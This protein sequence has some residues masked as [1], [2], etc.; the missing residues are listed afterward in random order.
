MMPSKFGVIRPYTSEISLFARLLD[1]IVI[2]LT[3]WSIL[4]MQGNIWDAKQ[5]WWLLVSIVTFFIFAEWN[6]IYKEKRGD[7]VFEVIKSILMAWMFVPVVMFFVEYS[8][9][10]VDPVYKE[11]YIIWIVTVP[12]EIASWHIFINS[13]YRIIRKK[14]R[15]SRRVAIIGAT[16]LGK[17]LERIF[18]EEEELGLKFIGYF[19]DRKKLREQETGEYKVVGNI[20][21]LIQ[22]AKN[23]EVDIIYIALALQAEQRIKEMLEELAD[24][25]IS[26]YFVP[27][28]FVFSLLRSSWSNLQGIPVVSIYDS[29]FYGVD[30]ALKRGFDICFSFITLICIFW[31]LLLI[32]VCIKLSSP[33]PV[34]FKQRRFGLKGEEI[35]VWKFRSMTV[36]E[37]G[38]KVDQAKKNDPRVT[39]L[40]AFLRR[41]SLDELPQFFNVLQGRMSV[42]GPRPHAVA[43]NEFYRGQIKGYMLRHKVKPGITGLA[44]ISGYRGETDT[45]DKMENRIR[46]DLEYIR[47]WSLAL[48]IK[49]IFLTLFKGFVGKKA[50]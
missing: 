10:L 28:L 4:E 31:L 34:I 13:L 27:N 50:Y 14:G 45:L 37:D 49:I 6:D 21:H 44:Q 23:S 9:P 2:G 48:D 7:F 42:V 24:T 18:L 35:V 43:H 19:D 15:N 46:C 29:P 11:S 39:K 16:T 17:E 32:A 25:T 41:T 8:Q 38:K 3:L 26:V 47:N 36:A 30:G 12:I 40:G 5:T 20:S 22:M 1:A 33:G